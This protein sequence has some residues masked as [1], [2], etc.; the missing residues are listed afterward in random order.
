MIIA[1]KPASSGNTVILENHQLDASKSIEIPAGM[2]FAE[3]VALVRSV[4]PDR[5]WKIIETF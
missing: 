4:E 1:Q 2:G 3:M 5:R